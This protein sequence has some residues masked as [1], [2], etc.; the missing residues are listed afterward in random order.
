MKKKHYDKSLELNVH[1]L[2]SL[3]EVMATNSALKNVL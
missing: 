3:H 2:F 1:D